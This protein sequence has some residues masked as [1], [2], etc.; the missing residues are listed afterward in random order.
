ML[1]Y[2]AQLFS[3]QERKWKIGGELKEPSRDDIAA[4]IN[5]IITMT[6]DG[7][8]IELGGLLVKNEGG[9]K[10]LYVYLGDV[11]EETFE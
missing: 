1:D 9:R 5:K 8:Q 11:D 10:E 6:D 7:L 4:V 2:I 3:V